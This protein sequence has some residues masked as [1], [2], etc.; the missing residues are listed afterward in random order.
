VVLKLVNFYH[1]YNSFSEVR[2][3]REKKKKLGGEKKRGT[4]WFSR[5]PLRLRPP[6]P[7][8]VGRRKEGAG[9]KGKSEKKRDCGY[10]YLLP[11]NRNFVKEGKRKKG[12]KKKGGD[13]TQINPPRGS[14]VPSSLYLPSRHL[15]RS[16]K[17]RKKGGKKKND[18][19]KKKKGKRGRTGEGP[20]RHLTS[21]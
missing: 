19:E 15:H 13:T 11:R 3:N 18:W 6:P 10:L 7:G 14:K 4:N 9:K 16:P 2:P 8:P 1:P 12:L 21:T 17:V 20:S 5:N